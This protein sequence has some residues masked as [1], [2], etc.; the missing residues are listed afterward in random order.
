MK[1]RIIFYFLIVSVTLQIGFAQENKIKKANEEFFNYDFIDARKI[2]L[3]VVAD[4]YESAQVFQKLGDTYYF[5]SEYTEAAVWYQKLIDS[6][7]EEVLPEYYFRAAQSLKSVGDYEGSNKMMALFMEASNDSMVA[8]NHDGATR[9]LTALEEPLHKSFTI[10]NITGAQPK[11]DFG[12]AFFG[13]KI[14]FAS[15]SMNT[16]GG[17]VDEWTGQP[18]LDLFEAEVQGD[19]TLGKIEALKGG[20]NSPYHESSAAV[21]K[22]GGTI[23]FTRN[24]YINGK[25]KRGN[26]RL[27]SLKIYK[28]NKQEDG[29]WGNVVELPFNDD[30]YST[31]HPA[32]NPEE[33]R[34]YFSSNRD[35]TLGR[36]DI[37]FVDIHENGTYG[38]P[39]NLGPKINTEE[40]ETFPFISSAN[41]L[42]FSSDGH[43]GL[44]GLDVF[45]FSLDQNGDYPKV[46]NLKKPIN[47]NQD[48]FAFI[49]DENTKRGYLSSNRNGI[50]GS[51]SDDIYRVFED[52][53]ITVQGLVTDAT[54]GHPLPGAQVM[55]I[56]SK[57][58]VIEKQQTGNNGKYK[59]ENGIECNSQ[60]AIRATFNEQ[61]YQ[62]TEKIVTT[63]KTSGSLQV[64]L[65]L[66][67]PVCPVDDLGCRLALQPIYFDFDKHDIRPDAEVE[68]AKILQAMKTYPQLKIHIESHTDS[69]G[70]DNYNLQLSE[71]RAKST[72]EWLVSKGIDRQRLSAKGYGETQLINSCGNG[73]D[74]SKEA[75]QLNR[76]SMF[77]IKN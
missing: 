3:Q 39:V 2:Y 16:V 24:N 14:V 47:S 59:F 44:G 70:D 54:N 43:L 46:T 9:S 64:N 13:D 45:V 76:R 30:S 21:T 19:S 51:L 26:Q 60:Y 41:N 36:S 65:E 25:R 38:N 34:L 75:H 74:C 1:T 40:R 7:P 52:C 17:K 22:D 57:N 31:A 29:S 56:N 55:L 11:S 48:D 49:F 73:V 71:R 10:K 23:Y 20:I 68:L 62:P 66:V 50:Q 28:A 37:W 33:T 4:G 15:S 53:M 18:Y 5:N 63:P 77:I 8:E 69:R 32:L 27:V 67:P 58:E 42:Y 35:G 72:L 12:A 6:F 61:E